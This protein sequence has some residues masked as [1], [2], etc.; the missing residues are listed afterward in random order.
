M[1]WAFK[2]KKKSVSFK[3]VKMSSR[4][5]SLNHESEEILCCS[6]IALSS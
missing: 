5:A 3:E 1:C 2:L 4:D 6:V